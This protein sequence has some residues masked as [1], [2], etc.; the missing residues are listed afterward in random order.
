MWVCSRQRR[1]PRRYRCEFHHPGGQRR[2]LAPPRRD[3]PLPRGSGYAEY[4]GHRHSAP[5]RCCRRKPPAARPRK[6]ISLFWK[7][8]SK[9]AAIS[10]PP[11]EIAHVFAN[12]GIGV[13]GNRLP[14]GGGRKSVGEGKGWSVRVGLGGRRIIK[15]KKK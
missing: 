10:L 6:Q 11:H 14:C 3:R 1:R 2:G 12:G 9:D 4:R 5:A 8:F 13:A 7:G 15:K